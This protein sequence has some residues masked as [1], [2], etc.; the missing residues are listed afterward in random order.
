MHRLFLLIFVAPFWLQFIFAGGLAY[1]GYTL[2]ETHAERIAH[3]AELLQAAPP[4]TME[5]AAFNQK[6]ASDTPT[7]V[8][9][10][11]Q[12]AVEHNTRLVRKRNFITVGEDVLYV[13]VDADAPADETVARGA[14]VVDPDQVDALVDWMVTN[15]AG[16]G[17]GGPVV[18]VD[19]L[20][21]YGTQNS[22]VSDALADQGM[23]KGPNFFFVAPY[24]EG[25]AAALAVK[26]GEAMDGGM[27]VYYA[28]LFFALLGVA[29]LYFRRRNGGPKA[30]KTKPATIGMAEPVQR[31]V[32][33]PAMEPTTHVQPTAATLTQTGAHRAG[34]AEYEVPGQDG[35]SLE[36]AMRARVEAAMANPKA[37]FVA[38]VGD[39]AIAAS[40]IA[41]V[42]KVTPKSMF[43][44]VSSMGPMKFGILAV[45][46]VAV[47]Q[48]LFPQLIMM[49]LPF[50]FLGL[51]Y[52]V[53]Y[54]AS[55]KFKSTVGNVVDSVTDKIFADKVSATATKPTPTPAPLT[56]SASVA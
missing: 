34:I 14:I 50:V 35:Q 33:Q 42:A 48:R 37:A 23:T 21:D 43:E 46:V 18:K 52:F 16:L 25:R 45:A 39:A 55:S 56:P 6:Y 10:T 12:I 30:D 19:G 1:F 24:I 49:V 5:I 11:A 53:F 41:P 3:R 31:P 47:V 13:L 29:K 51:F 7:E 17:Q 15:A 22:M 44:Q 4:A 20:L 54:K 32:E 2:Q 8:S 28:A 36:A 38:P 27:P 40:L 26:P 9:V